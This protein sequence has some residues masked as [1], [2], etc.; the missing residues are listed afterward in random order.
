MHFWNNSLIHAD[1]WLLKE[2]VV[3]LLSAKNILLTPPQ[4]GLHYSAKYM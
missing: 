2:A 3:H 1:F 4:F